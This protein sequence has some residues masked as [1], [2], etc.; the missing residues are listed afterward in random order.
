MVD[1]RTRVEPE[2]GFRR[3]LINGHGCTESLNHVPS[4]GQS[5]GR[6]QRSQTRDD[7][8]QQSLTVEDDT[9]PGGSSRHKDKE[10]VCEEK[11]F[12]VAVRRS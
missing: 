5:D 8:D 10:L 2:N 1:P 3:Q 6:R 11:A 12:L 7:V 9:C 4:M